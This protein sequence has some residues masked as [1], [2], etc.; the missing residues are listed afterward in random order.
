MK[1]KILIALTL[2]A[3]TSCMKMKKKGEDEPAVAAPA[4]PVTNQQPQEVKADV[5]EL[6][7]TYLPT[8]ERAAQPVQFLFPNHWPKTVYVKKDGGESLPVS[9]QGQWEDNLTSQEKVNYQFYSK[10]GMQFI[11]LDEV[12]V[13]PIL[14]LDVASDLNLAQKYKLSEK[15]RYIV[16]SE[17]SLAPQA[18]LYLEDFSGKIEIKKI[19]SNSGIIQTFANDS[20]GDQDQNGKSGGNINFQI[21]S[22]TGFLKIVMKGQNGASGA[23]AKPSDMALMGL[24]GNRGTP[25]EFNRVA[26]DVFNVPIYFYNCVVGPGVGGNGED[27]KQGYPG[28]N[29]KNGGHSGTALIENMTSDLIVSMDAISGEKGIGSVGGAG[30]IGGQPGRGGDGNQDDLAIYVRSHGFPETTPILSNACMAAPSGVQGKQGTNG[31]NGV[32]GKNGEIQQVCLITAD[33]KQQCN[34]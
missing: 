3:F 32:D 21:Q 17:L 1:H 12:E 9:N 14:K 2:I 28:N 6:V 16:F 5:T 30:G 13:L 20:C 19:Y 11:L 29:G 23:P 10:V 27:G 15:T 4:R 31:L 8:E 22:G 34:K 18:H 25:A 33:N 26:G 24:P 7:Y